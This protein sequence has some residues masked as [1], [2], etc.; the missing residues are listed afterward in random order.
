MSY[1]KVKTGNAKKKSTAQKN[2]SSGTGKKILLLV[3]AV[4]LVG[5]LGG[6]IIGAIYSPSRSECKKIIAEFQESCN[7]L[8]TNGILNCLK[9]SVSN[10]L[11]IALG[12]GSAVTSQS[13]DEMLE[14]ILEALGGGMSEITENTDLSVKSL[15]ETMELH[16]KRFG[17]PGRTRKVKCKAIVGGLQQNV[18][19][20]ITKW[21][22]DPYISKVSFRD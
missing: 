3:A 13:S 4:F 18:Y 17:L 16:A 12:I 14:N 20:Y 1:R 11:K 19:I 9:P 5:L 8:D 10:P 2:T 15:F 6:T 22:G 7:E 21:D